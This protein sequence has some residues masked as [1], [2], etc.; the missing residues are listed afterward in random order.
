M[1]PR[2]VTM[3][4]L[5]LSDWEKE[6]AK[7]LSISAP[8]A[9]TLEYFASGACDEV[10]L[11][12][13]LE[14]FKEVSLVPRVLVDV[15]KTS[16]ASQILGFNSAFPFGIAPTAFQRLVDPD[17]EINTA[18]AGAAINVP[19]CVSSFAT[20]SLEDIAIAGGK[21]GIRLMQLYAME[22]RNVTR[23]IIE[24]AE[25]SGYKAIVL[26]VDRPVLGRRESNMRTKFDVPWELHRDPNHL[27]GDNVVSSS[28]ASAS[29]SGSAGASALYA[30]ISSELTWDDVKWIQSITSLP[31][32]LKGIVSV[33]DARLA[34]Q[35]GVAAVWVSNHGGRQLD[36]SVSGLDAL[37]TVASAVR[38]EEERLLSYSFF[39]RRSSP[40]RIEI[41][42]DGG[43]RRG[44]D[45]VK[46]LALG[47]DF[48]F[49][50]R[51]VIW[52]LAVSG[53]EGV[54]TVLQTLAEETL[55]AMQLCGSTSV[56]QINRELVVP[57]GIRYR[58]YHHHQYNNRREPW[59]GRG[60]RQRWFEI[61]I[62]LLLGVSLGSVL[63][64]RLKGS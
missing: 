40:R 58:S 51:P 10:T 42:V 6:A 37:P 22:N 34:V 2:A 60:G 16:L 15:S 14:C 7:K 27:N 31:V 46:A 32:I 41:Y 44:T 48:V 25:K 63:A 36:C 57:R 43:V 4:F 52:G 12:R 30:A 59:K 64:L 9:G 26:T 23:N 39:T 62:A 11:H 13:N 50:G 17:G 3:A 19:Y 5:S 29:A 45:V 54:K 33:E 35:A 21:N 8:V 20:S 49:I 56:S 1:Q 18:R 53:E 61:G 28:S 24:R 38:E 55:N 47:A